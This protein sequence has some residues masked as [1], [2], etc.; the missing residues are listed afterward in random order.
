MISNV[1]NEY[2]IINLK[3]FKVNTQQYNIYI[4]ITVYLK[5]GDK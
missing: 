1:K 2:T 4:F 5:W 3:T